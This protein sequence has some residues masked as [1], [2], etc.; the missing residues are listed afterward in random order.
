[1]S[2]RNSKFL[3]F[4]TV[5]ITRSDIIWGLLE[6]EVLVERAS[7]SADIYR[8]TDSDV[9][10]IMDALQNYDIA[11]SQNF[12]PSLA[13]ACK[14]LGK[15]YISWVYDCPQIQLYY[16][17]ALFDSNYIF[18]FDKAET[19]C[20]MNKG[21]KH[22]YW[23]PLAANTLMI[24]SHVITDEAINKYN[25]DVS[26]V[27]SLYKRDYISR[28]LNSLPNNILSELNEYTNNRLCKYIANDSYSSGITDDYSE[29]FYK[30]G[31]I[32]RDYNNVPI[33]KDRLVELLINYPYLS[34]LER[35]TL[36]N[37]AAQE[38][39]TRLYTRETNVS[40]VN[41]KICQ[42]VSVDDEL[43]DV[44]FSSKVNLNITW[45]GITSGVSQ[46][47]FDIMAVG[48]FVLSSYQSEMDD[49]FIIGNEIEVFHDIKEYKEKLDY[50]LHNERAR[51]E[52]ALNGYKKVQEL[53]NYKNAINAIFS[54]VDQS[55]A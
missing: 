53:Y 46:R 9:N 4:D 32:D 44:Y 34:S 16:N 8:Y 18:M 30:N 36:I 29:Y 21:I 42:P 50:Y 49:L 11:F 13:T 52:I 55:I 1:M 45:R 20:L 24:N 35:V 39:D 25:C 5:Q 6:Q 12:V 41:A 15:I 23:L 54:I 22:I 26:F 48:G 33:E 47:V 38:Y 17:E 14:K 43:F 3:Y 19:E 37:I 28:I 7:F 51:L 27:G 10:A 31:F 40:D 2:I